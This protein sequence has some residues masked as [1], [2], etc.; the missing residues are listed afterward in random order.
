MFSLGA[1]NL[2]SGSDVRPGGV[3]QQ[4]WEVDFSVSSQGPP[5]IVH[6]GA[7]ATAISE[8]VNLNLGRLRL[9]YKSPVAFDRSYTLATTS[10]SSC[11][12]KSK[13]NIAVSATF[14]HAADAAVRWAPVGDVIDAPI[15]DI[16]PPAAIGRNVSDQGYATNFLDGRVLLR[17]YQHGQK[18]NVFARFTPYAE[19]PG[20]RGR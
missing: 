7:I 15:G 5:N 1:L 13:D 18:V 2:R 11:I 16:L 8:A 19:D 14:E 4:A 10:P 3:E 17:T 12:L 9:E 6:G 20:A